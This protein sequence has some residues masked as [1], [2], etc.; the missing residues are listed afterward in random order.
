MTSITEKIP[1]HPDFILEKQLQEFIV[2]NFDQIFEDKLILLRD[3]NGKPQEEYYTDVGKIDILA[4]E[5]KENSYVVI[6]LKTTRESDK[7]VGQILRYMGWVKENL[8]KEGE[9]VKG[10]LICG[11]QDDR[12]IY[13]LKHT[14]NINL[15]FFRMEFQLFDKDT[16]TL[17][18]SP[19]KRP[20]SVIP[21]DLDKILNEFLDEEDYEAVDIQRL[22]EHGVYRGFNEKDVYFR[23]NQMLREGLLFQPKKG[24]VRKPREWSSDWFL[25][26]IQSILEQDELEEIP[27]KIVIEN[28][29][30]EG[31]DESF[32][33]DRIKE[34]IRKGSLFSPRK[35]YITVFD[36]Y[37]ET[38]R[39]SASARRKLDQLDIL[40]E[41]ML[42][43]AE[44]ECVFIKDIV[45]RAI[46][47]GLN[48]AQ[49]ENAID[50]MTR[51]G[52]LFE[53]QPKC[54]KYP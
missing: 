19:K 14:K 5:L 21:I 41:K 16:F 17:L 9:H 24:Y 1:I 36:L 3:S 46:E 38:R 23:V 20:K 35:D 34:M 39:I 26:A 11:S 6:E 52:I 18:K 30:K 12:I 50:N 28:G 32:L 37:F 31:F 51:R 25:E 27:T 44:G 10:L 8:C 22:I 47:E 40:I 53:P 49:V 48:K 33:K 45:E 7:A 4:R 15:M 29:L 2:A 43:E 42:E 54:V 13:A